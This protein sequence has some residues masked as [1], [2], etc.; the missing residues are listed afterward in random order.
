MDTKEIVEFSK[1][2]KVQW[3]TTII[4]LLVIL[5]VGANIRLQPITT[6]HLIDKTTGNYTPLAL[7][8]IIF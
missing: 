1:N 5:T 6:G 2:K 8:P 4:L 7:T 3:A